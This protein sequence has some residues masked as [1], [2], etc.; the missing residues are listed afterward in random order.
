MAFAD[1]IESYRA[2][3][4]QALAR[5]LPDP[6]LTP[7][8][9]HEAMRYAVLG[10]GKRLRPLLV[11]ATGEA[12]QVDPA[13]LDPPA[14]AIE[15]MHAFS[16][17]HDD[18]P[19]MDDDDMRRGRPSTHRAFDEATAILAADALQPLAFEVLVTAPALAAE[20]EL[21]LRLVALLSEAC[22]PNGIAGGQALD[23]GA[24]RQHLDPAELEHMFRLKTGRLLRASVLAAAHCAGPP[25]TQRLHRLEVFADALGIAYQIRDDVI[26]FT[27]AGH[28]ASSDAVKAKATY[29]AL[30]GLEQANR[31]AAELQSIAMAAIDDLGEP[32]AGL[33]WMARHTMLRSA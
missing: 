26:D 33:R 11:Y 31:R 32:A 12:L 24:E 25:T 7:Q 28:E 9:L 14:V 13:R 29:P 18:L 8:R 21:Q 23:L 22:G 3:I 6:G 27:A 15:L 10:G 30:F 20:P 4:E 16:L 2:R 17:I 1:R 5:A 19:C